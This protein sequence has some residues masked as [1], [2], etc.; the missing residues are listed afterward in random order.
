MLHS[1]LEGFLERLKDKSHILEILPAYSLTCCLKAGEESS[2]FVL[3][4]DGMEI[5]ETFNSMDIKIEGPEHLI[6]DLLTGSTKMT[7]EKIMFRGSFRQW[8][9]VDSL[10]TLAKKT[11]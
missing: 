8:L 6:S 4:R 10:F 3:S 7:H 5:V 9:L 2:F 1:M 11:S